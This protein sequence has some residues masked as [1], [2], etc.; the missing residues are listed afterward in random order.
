MQR[1]VLRFDSL[2]PPTPPPQAV[3][4]FVLASSF[5]LADALETQPSSLMHIAEAV[6]TGDR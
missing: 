1:S 3:W 6:L 4:R 5:M 2:A